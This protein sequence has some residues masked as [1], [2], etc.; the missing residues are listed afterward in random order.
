MLK[1]DEVESQSSSSNM[2]DTL[3]P[4][5]R[6]LRTSSFLHTAANLTKLYIGITLISVSKSISNVGIYT[7]IFGFGYVFFLNGYSLYLVIKARNRFKNES[8]TDLADLGARV[9]GEQARKYVVTA[10]FITNFAFLSTYSLFFGEQLNQ[11]LC[12][13]T[14]ASQIC[15][16]QRYYAFMVN[17]LL[18]PVLL[19]KDF[20]RIGT[21]NCIILVFTFVSFSI[22]LYVTVTILRQS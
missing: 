17:I 21:F 22:I 19:T 12:E 8:I 9:Y 6:L 14:S 3:Q 15:G 7:A 20:R 5:D 1:K 18:L 10:I 16:H 13:G 4:A 2:S 11:L